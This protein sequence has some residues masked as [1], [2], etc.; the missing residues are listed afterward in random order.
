MSNGLGRTLA[1][2]DNRVYAVLLVLVYADASFMPY[3][4]NWMATLMN[5]NILRAS[6][7]LLVVAGLLGCGPES[8]TSAE[9]EPSASVSG[10]VQPVGSDALGQCPT[11][12]GASLSDRDRAAL[13]DGRGDAQPLCLF[14]ASFAWADHDRQKAS[15]LYALAMVRYRYDAVRCA[16]PVPDALVSSMVAARMAAGDRLASLG[17]FVGPKEI[18]AAAQRSESYTYPVGHL[19]AQCDGKL[20]PESEWGGL[21]L[22]M[23][24]AIAKAQARPQTGL[25]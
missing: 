17:I 5:V 18:G 25:P 21:R 19:Q 10:V 20:R 11:S 8:A 3:T 4:V 12:M 13:W 22:E 6:I 15:D 2:L 16:A 9:R 24:D 7:S 1:T 14:V 23:Q